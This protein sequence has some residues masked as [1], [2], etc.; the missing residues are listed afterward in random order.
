MEGPLRY[1]H[2][3]AR[4]AHLRQ[5][6]IV[7][8]ILLDGYNTRRDIHRCHVRLVGKGILAD[9]YNPVGRTIMLHL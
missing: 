1:L 8:G 7:E 5:T 9:T 4:N 2:T 6:S 3:V